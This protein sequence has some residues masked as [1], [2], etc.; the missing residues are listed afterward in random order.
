MKKFG[1]VGKLL[2]ALS[3]ATGYDELNSVYCQYQTLYS[4]K[5]SKRT[6]A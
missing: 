1:E 4:A 3:Y 5:P 6:L 2:K